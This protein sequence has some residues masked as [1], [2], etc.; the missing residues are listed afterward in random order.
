MREFRIDTTA[1]TLDNVTIA[2]SNSVSTLA[3]TGDNSPCPSP[4]QKRIQTPSVRIAGQTATVTGDN[5]TWS[6]AYTM[7]GGDSTRIGEPEHSLQ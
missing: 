1:P 2:S 6:A 4:L 7:A 5:M 3:K